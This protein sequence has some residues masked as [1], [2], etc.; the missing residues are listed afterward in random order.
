[1]DGHVSKPFKQAVLLSALENVTMAPKD[2]QRNIEP[3][4]AAPPDTGSG[5]PI[6]DRATFDDISAILSGAD[7]ENNLQLLITRFEALLCELRM[8]GLLSRAGELAEAA[9]GLAGGAGTFGF[10]YVAAAA[11]QFEVAADM[12]APETEALGDH[13]AAAIEASVAVTRQEF[14]AIAADGR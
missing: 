8:P 3:P 2:T 10:L 14:S 7:L 4:T 9:H 5:F 13:L 12:G 1:M 11:R 6:L